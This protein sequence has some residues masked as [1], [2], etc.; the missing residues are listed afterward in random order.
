MA[1]SPPQHGSIDDA[2]R[3]QMGIAAPKSRKL[4]RCV[5]LDHWSAKNADLF[6]VAL[7]NCSH[8]PVVPQ[9]DCRTSRPTQLPSGCVDERKAGEHDAYQQCVPQGHVTS[10]DDLDNHLSSDRAG[11]QGHA[12]LGRQAH[13]T[14][15]ASTID[16]GR[17]PP[18]LWS[19]T[20]GQ[21]P[22][23]GHCLRVPP[24]PPSQVSCRIAE[25]GTSRALREPSTPKATAWPPNA[26]TAVPWSTNLAFWFPIPPS[27]QVWRRGPRANSSTSQLTNDATSGAS[28][29]CGLTSR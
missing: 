27:D 26:V 24:V 9:A 6:S 11:G 23:C 4:G 1:R 18:A 22:S 17:R 10:A 15:M 3:L 20:E 16:A 25:S 29:R 13:V 8:S 5:R 28:A 7:N 14:R 19:G 21:Q 12:R 2:M